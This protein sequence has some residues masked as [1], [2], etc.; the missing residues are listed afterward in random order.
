M[1]G[2]RCLRRYLARTGHEGRAD[3]RTRL[4]ASGALVPGDRTVAGHRRRPD[5][6]PATSP[7]VLDELREERLTS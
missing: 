3:L 1:I 4:I 2:I 6:N 7:T 5:S